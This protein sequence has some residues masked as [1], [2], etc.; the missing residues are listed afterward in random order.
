VNRHARRALGFLALVSAAGGVFLAASW[1]AARRLA[2]RLISAT[3]LGPTASTREDLLAALEARAPIVKEFRHPGSR[4]DPVE[5]A[6]TFASSGDPAKRPTLL[7]LHGKGGHS[8]EW[9]PDALR[10]LSLGYNVLLPDLRGH[11]ASGGRYMTF[12]FLERDDLANALDAARELWDVDPNRVGIHSCSAGSAVALELAAH[13]IGVRAIWLES[14]FADP[15]S[16]ARHYLAAATGIPAPLLALTTRWAVARTLGRVKRDLR[17]EDVAG[18]LEKADPLA[19]L[20]RVRCPIELVYGGGDRLIPPQFVERFVAGL[21]PGSEIFAVPGAG[22]CHHPNEAAVVARDEYV[23]R[24]TAFFA[25]HLPV[26]DSP[27]S[28]AQSPT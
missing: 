21:P 7:F 22:H 4:L 10:A 20:A 23:R 27:R 6:A 15:R 8:S 11:G 2:D 25:E 17:L 26:D 12:G 1:F 5:L 16:M 24:W 3:G 28:K 9:Q 14:P 19:A 13:R 18:G